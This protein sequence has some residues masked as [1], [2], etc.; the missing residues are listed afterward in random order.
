[1][2][3]LLDDPV[4]MFHALKDLPVSV[5][6]TAPHA[7]NWHMGLLGQNHLLD[8]SDARLGPG[9]LDII[10]FLETY[11]LLYVEDDLPRTLWPSSSDR[12]NRDDVHV[13]VR[14]LTPALEETVLDG[15]LLAMSAELG[16]RFPA[17]Q[18]RQ[19]MPAARCLYV[20][21][22]W[23]PYFATWAAD[24]P[25]KY[26]WQRVNR[27]SEAELS[28]NGLGPMVGIRPYFAGVFERFLHA[29]RNL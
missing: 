29:Y 1:M 4:P 16:S 6:H 14:E 24:M 7:Y 28:E 5:L 9:V 19:A 22:N 18:L 26:V 2:A 25:N 20:L 11:P 21:T 12:A 17:R 27:M 13:R 15:Y 23:L 8:W 10:A 3:D